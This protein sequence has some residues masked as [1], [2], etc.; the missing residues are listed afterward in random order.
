M[1]V[2]KNYDKWLVY[3]TAY[4]KTVRG[5]HT[6]QLRLYAIRSRSGRGFVDCIRPWYTAH[7]AADYFNFK[8]TI[9]DYLRL[10]INNS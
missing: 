7:R 1:Q 2:D 4:Y 6:T 5:G 8:L 10:R 3:T 9:W